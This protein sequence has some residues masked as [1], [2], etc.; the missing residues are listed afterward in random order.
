[1]VA[2]GVPGFEIWLRE[3]RAADRH[4]LIRGDA[5]REGLAREVDDTS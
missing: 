4:D 1:M 2:N 5:R 3:P